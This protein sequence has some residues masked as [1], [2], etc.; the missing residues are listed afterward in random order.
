MSH[1]FKEGYTASWLKKE[2]THLVKMTNRFSSITLATLMKR[3]LIP[4]WT[5]VSRLPPHFSCLHHVELSDSSVIEGDASLLNHW[6]SYWLS[7]LAMCNRSFVSPLWSI[8]SCCVDPIVGWSH[9]IL[10][11]ELSRKLDVCWWLVEQKFFVAYFDWEPE[12]HL[13]HVDC[14]HPMRSLIMTLK[15]KSIQILICII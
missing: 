1:Y 9:S 7:M 13:A 10:K 3:F 5:R 4:L 11:G 15:L 6:R 8:F 14:L 2:N 12:D